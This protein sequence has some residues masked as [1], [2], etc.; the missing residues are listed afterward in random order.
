MTRSSMRRGLPDCSSLSATEQFH[1]LP[2][3]DNM[4]EAEKFLALGGG[5]CGPPPP[6]SCM[7]VS[8]MSDKPEK[9]YRMRVEVTEDKSD[10]L[11][12]PEARI[13]PGLIDPVKSVQDRAWLSGN[14][15][16]KLYP[17]CSPDKEI[18]NP[19]DGSV[20]VAP[21]ECKVMIQ[22]QLLKS[23]G[24]SK[25][26]GV[27]T[28]YGISAQ[29]IQSVVVSEDGNYE[30]VTQVFRVNY[31][32]NSGWGCLILRCM[33]ETLVY[34]SECYKQ[35]ELLTLFFHR[36]RE[37]YE[38]APYPPMITLTRLQDQNYVPMLPG[39]ML[40][41]VPNVGTT[42]ID[43]YQSNGD[44]CLLFNSIERLTKNGKFWCH[45][46]DCLRIPTN[47]QSF[48]VKGESSASV[49]IPP[50]HCHDKDIFVVVTEPYKSVKVD[51]SN[52]T[53][54]RI[55]FARNIPVIEHPT[56]FMDIPRANTQ[57]HELAVTFLQKL[58][59]VTILHENGTCSLSCTLPGLGTCHPPSKKSR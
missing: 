5:L 17:Y 2:F 41:I 24:G 9:V 11:T 40:Q 36:T 8:T 18:G 10:S 57:V 55:R 47:H 38:Q 43:D 4:L 21:G 15:P 7:A 22:S 52:I 54:L 50:V 6:S 13:R 1:L 59:T 26:W 3:V 32:E 51:C 39:Q 48:F 53:S 29:Q 20:I 28:K 25:T 58:D 27:F 35:N 16:K 19:V 49:I 34:G 31:A 33:N 46:Y 45:R 37:D 23:E 12:V 44:R 14:R 42:G 56:K 30:T